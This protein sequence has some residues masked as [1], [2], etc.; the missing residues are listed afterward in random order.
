MANQLSVS[1]VIPTCNREQLLAHCLDALAAAIR[2]S[3]RDLEVV[4]ADDSTDEGSRRLIESNYSWVRWVRGPRRGPAANRNAGVAASSGDWI[5]FTD[6]DCTPGP[7]WLNAYLQAIYRHPGCSVFEGKTIADRERLRLDEESPVNTRGGYL[8]SC[9][10]ALERRTFQRVGG[11]CESFPFPAM[12]DV[13]FRLRLRA[14]GQAATFIPEAVVCHPY[15]ASK[16][17]SFAV[18]AGRSYLHL[19]ARHPQLL[20][21]APWRTLAANLCRRTWLLMQDAARYR[22]R[23]FGLAFTALLIG[24]YFE[25]VARWRSAFG[26]EQM[27]SSQHH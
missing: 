14:D 16:G 5:F 13:D 2:A 12:E 3:G 27:L 18:S 1:V 6:D 4:V 26:R 24:A 9:N 15:R 10:M 19:V 23:G 11:F 7:G 17:V 20:G 22:F 8:W 21:K 25:A